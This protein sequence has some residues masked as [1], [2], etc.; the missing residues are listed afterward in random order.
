[1]DGPTMGVKRAIL[2]AESGHKRPKWHPSR[3]MGAEHM[4][5]SPHSLP[6]SSLMASNPAS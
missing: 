5:A 3:K 2:A 1:M 4:T 6:T